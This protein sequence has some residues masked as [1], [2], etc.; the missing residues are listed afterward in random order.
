MKARC[1]KIKIKNPSFEYPRL[2][3]VDNASEALQKFFRET[4][5]DCELSQDVKHF[6]NRLIEHLHRGND[7][8]SVLSTA[9]HG[10]FTSI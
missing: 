6:V 5:P 1:D 2:F 3:Y 9:L 8:Y 10:A 4:F 7:Q